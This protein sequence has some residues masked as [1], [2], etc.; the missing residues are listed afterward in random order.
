MAVDLSPYGINATL[1]ARP[2]SLA[3]LVHKETAVISGREYE[4]SVLKE[5][6]LTNWTGSRRTLK[7][8]RCKLLGRGGFGQVCELR[9]GDQIYAMKEMSLDVQPLSSV[10]NEM[11]I[12]ILLYNV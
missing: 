3:S 10:I 11:L 7:I 4:G 5:C 9:M 6:T 12:H 8:D 2:D 1:Y